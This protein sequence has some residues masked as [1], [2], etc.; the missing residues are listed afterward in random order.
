M[1]AGEFL[2]LL[3][4]DMQNLTVDTN[5]AKSYQHFIEYFKDTSKIE[6]KHFFIS[7][8]FV[9]GWM[10]TILNYKSDEIE[11][12]IKLLNRVKEI[13]SISA[14]KEKLLS[15]EELETLKSTINNSIIGTSKLLHF[16]RPDYYAIWDSR[17]CTYLY[18]S[19]SKVGKI[20]TFL[21][22]IEFIKKLIKHP[23]FDGFYSD[24]KEKFDDP[25]VDRIRAIENTIFHLSRE[26]SEQK[27]PAR[28]VSSAN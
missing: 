24:Y 20:D 18:G 3:K 9:Y 2:A 26:T 23:N 25:T 1:T 4:K 5:Y 8:N 12:C 28:E 14:E 17:I 27:N 19:K 11:K 22:Y 13:K 10:P 16:I 15:K 6:E 21:E 7:T